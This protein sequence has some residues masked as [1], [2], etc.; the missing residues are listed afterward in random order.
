MLG[1]SVAGSA[2][3]SLGVSDAEAS[4]PEQ[5]VLPKRSKTA[6]DPT[7]MAKS[8][9]LLAMKALLPLVAIREL[10]PFLGGSFSMLRG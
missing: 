6:I 1:R 10:L 7:T 5:L 9:L 8:A 3:C 4:D 2:S